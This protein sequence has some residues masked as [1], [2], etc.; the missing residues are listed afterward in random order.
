MEDENREQ[1]RELREYIHKELKDLQAAQEKDREKSGKVWA[2]I[3]M[4]IGFV[5]AFNFIKD[6]LPTIWRGGAR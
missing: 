6:I 4:A 3:Y 2:W 5:A 1:M